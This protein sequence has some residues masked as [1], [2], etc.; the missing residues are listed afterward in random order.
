MKIGFGKK[1]ILGY[2]VLLEFFR[3]RKLENANEYWQAFA[4]YASPRQCQAKDS[5]KAKENVLI[6]NGPFGSYLISDTWQIPALKLFVIASGSVSK[7]RKHAKS[8]NF[9][10]IPRVMFSNAFYINTMLTSTAFIGICTI[11]APKLK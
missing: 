6:F 1:S 11:L 4:T 2:R 8:T 7:I 9:L 5:I 10:K 3:V